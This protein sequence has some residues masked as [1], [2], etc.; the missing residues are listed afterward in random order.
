MAS[1]GLGSAVR[2]ELRHAV[3]RS[4]TNETPDRKP[5]VDPVFLV[6][7]RQRISGMAN[8]ELCCIAVADMVSPGL[9]SADSACLP[10]V[11]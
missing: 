1:L 11:L 5:I 7:C 2:V 8:S 9:V 6:L 10:F 4:I 3:F